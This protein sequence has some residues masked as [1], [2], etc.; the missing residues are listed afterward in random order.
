MPGNT[1][2]KSR[3]AHC[4]TC[5]FS[6]RLILA[7]S[8]S[9]VSKTLIANQLKQSRAQRK[10]LD[11]PGFDHSDKGGAKYEAVTLEDVKLVAAKVLSED[12][13]LISVV[14]PGT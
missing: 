11:G 9:A 7:S 1:S 13:F 14:K 5:A 4:K 10:E 6:A 12:K 8:S 2:P 3:A